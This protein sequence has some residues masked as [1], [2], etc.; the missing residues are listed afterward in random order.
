V[1]DQLVEEAKAGRIA[2]NAATGHLGRPPGACVFCPMLEVGPC[3]YVDELEPLSEAPQLTAGSP[4]ADLQREKALQGALMA[5]VVENAPPV[6]EAWAD[7][8]DLDEPVT[9]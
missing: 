8:D 6:A 5:G 3:D 2:F 4:V 1:I 7:V 9:V